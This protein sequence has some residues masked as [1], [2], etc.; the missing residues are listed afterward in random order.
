MNS[1]LF[2]VGSTETVDLETGERVPVEGGGMRMLPGP[3]G[4]CEWCHVKHDPSQPH[5]QQSLAYQ[6][7]FHQLNGRWPTWSDAM[8]HC[9]TAVQQFWRKHLVELMQKLQIEIP[10]D[11]KEESDKE[12]PTPFKFFGGDGPPP[13]RLDGGG[14]SA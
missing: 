9:T 8:Q 2:T 10:D 5:N 14:R 13:I 6:M 1:K 3:P 7:K 12:P 11:L 4:T